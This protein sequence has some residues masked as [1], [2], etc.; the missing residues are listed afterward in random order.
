MRELTQH[1]IKEASGG[2]AIPT[3]DLSTLKLNIDL[4]QILGLSTV[5]VN[6]GVSFSAGAFSNISFSSPVGIGGDL[7]P[8]EDS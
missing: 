2:M 5:E 8:E 7:G 6:S 3:L 1:E 4:S